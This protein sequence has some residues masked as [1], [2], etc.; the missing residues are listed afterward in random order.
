MS[1]T[2]SVSSTPTIGTSVINVPSLVSQ[3]MTTEQYPITA[4]QNVTTSY[5]AKLTALGQVKSAVSTFQT[6]LSTLNSASSF[7][8]VNAT[9][10]DPAVLS[11][12]A[13]TSAAPGSYSLTVGNLAQSQTL[14]AAGQTSLSS[15]IGTGTATTLSF[16]F[17]T[18]TGN[19]LNA[20]T[21][22]YGTALTASTTTGGTTVTAPTGNLAV[23]ATITG[24]G[25]PA[26]TTIVSITDANNFV[27]S[28]AVTAT[29]AGVALQA[30]P[31]YT[32]AGSGVKTLT[33]DS[34]NNSLKAYAMR[35]MPPRW[36]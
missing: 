4:L 15:P 23:G 28:A 35:S 32:S 2:S 9:A 33:I 3:L 7:Q 8:S 27:I 10:S 30:S 22:K 13:L 36:A 31:T 6:A 17:G 1:T 16:D 12:T 24:A 14:V 19:T 20:A 29:G 21:G 18:I 34:T 5:Q 26:G 11:A 25:I